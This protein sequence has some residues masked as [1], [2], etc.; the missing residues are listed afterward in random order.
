MRG[1]DQKTRHLDLK[2][3]RLQ[4]HFPHENV[5][6]N[7][8]KPEN[9]IPCLTP[10]EERLISPRSPFMPIA[11]LPRGGRLSIRGNVVNVSSDVNSTV[12]TLPRLSQ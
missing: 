9:K 6:I 5:F 11:E 2:R 1:T 3:D 12:H 8:T 7:F 4:L 10:L